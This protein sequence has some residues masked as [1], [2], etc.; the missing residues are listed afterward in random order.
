VRR[1]VLTGSSGLIGSALAT[2]LVRSGLEVTRLVRRPPR[3]AAEISWDPLAADGAISPD[4]L[5]GADAVIHLAGAGIADGRWTETRKAQ[6]RDSRVLGT[7]ALVSVLCAMDHPPGVLLSASAIGWYGDTGS[8]EVDESAPAG[9]GFLAGLARE[10]EAAAEPAAKAGIRV[11][12]LRSGIVVSRRGGMLA[13]LVPLFRLGLGARLGPGTQYLSWI[14]LT[15]EVGAIRFLLDRSDQ[16]GPVNLTAPG[17]VSNAAFTAAMAAA[18]HRP[19]V[20]RV[21]AVA[22]RTA[23]GEVSSELLGSA[24]VLP[25]RLEQAGFSFRHPEISGALAA[26]LAPGNSAP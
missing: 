26:E 22:L 1:V 21:P 14:T 17:P 4:A 3:T 12:N 7:Q 5:G 20:L 16:S 25:R 18:L 19:A 15:D 9:S 23:L 10:W 2:S 11:V 6:I 24:R 8:R 13:R